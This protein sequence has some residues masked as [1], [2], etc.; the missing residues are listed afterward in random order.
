[1]EL[2]DMYGLAGMFIFLVALCVAGQ[3]IAHYFVR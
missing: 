3:L 1:M 2:D